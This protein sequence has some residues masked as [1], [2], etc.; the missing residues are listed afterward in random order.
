MELVFPL[1]LAGMVALVVIGVLL[2]RRRQRAL[3]AWARANG[4]TYEAAR[5]DL[6]HLQR[7]FPFGQGRRR[8]ATEVLRGSYDAL[9]ALSFR[10]RWT[11]GTGKSRTEHSVHVVAVPMP[12][13]LATLEVTPE[14]V[15][16][17]LAKA[18]GAQDIQFES[19][20]FNRAF[21]IAAGDLAFAHAVLAPRLMEYLLRP[22][23]AR[24]PWRIEGPWI[25]SWET[26]GTNTAVL[27]RRLAQLAAVVRAIPR[28]VWQD[29]G[30]DPHDSAVGTY[31]PPRPG[32]TH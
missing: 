18:F 27:G 12:A 13:F 20:D 32:L 25:V 6:I 28:H 15:G 19:E 14:G 30:Y 4:W 24:S 2:D 26:G 11:T 22:D 9:P 1:F 3:Q 10:Y 8:T 17:R 31:P 23:A 5:A 16:A 7:G 29:H 21:R